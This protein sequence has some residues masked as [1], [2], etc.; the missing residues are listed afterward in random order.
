[1]GIVLA[2]YFLGLRKKKGWSI[3]D[4]FAKLDVLDGFLVAWSF[5]FLLLIIKFGFIAGLMTTGLSYFT[6]FWSG[7]TLF[8]F[9][10]NVRAPKET[11]LLLSFSIFF[12]VLFTFD[13]VWVILD[14][15]VNTRPFS[16]NHFIIDH[17]RNVIIILTCLIFSLKLSR[18]KWKIRRTSLLLAILFSS[19]M[20]ALWI[21]A[22][23]P[24]FRDS[25][26]SLS[27][28]YWFA[29]MRLGANLILYSIRISTDIAKP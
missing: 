24:D 18:G 17:L 16:L 28:V 4:L 20:F 5:C 27:F 2:I 3:E 10:R 21:Y 13:E 15:L 14:D 29:S 7:I 1:M 19:C 6:L 8:L 25:D 9:K 22:G 23:F 26:R 12:F 11:M